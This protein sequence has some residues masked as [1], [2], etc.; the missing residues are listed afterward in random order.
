MAGSWWKQRS[1]KKKGREGSEIEGIS[2]GFVV[3]TISLSRLE[4]TKG[5]AALFAKRQGNWDNGVDVIGFGAMN[6][7]RLYRVQRVLLDGEAPIEEQ[8]LSPGGSAANTIYGL[9]KLGVKTGFMGAIGDDDEGQ[10]LVTDFQSVGTDASQIKIK[11]KAATGLVLCLT[12]KRGMRTLY[13]SPGANSLLTWQDI[14]LEYLN[15][16]RIIHL[17]S[18]VDDAQFDLQHQVLS[19]ISPT[20]MVSLAPGALYAK[21]GW[22][23]LAPFIRRAHILFLNQNELKELTGE[24]MEKGARRCSGEGCPIVVVTLGQGVDKKRPIACYIND[25]GQEYAIELPRSEKQPVVD[26]TGAGDAFA[27]GFLYGL[28]REKNLQECGYLGDIVA[29]LSIA[30]LGARPGLP[31]LP[32]LSQEYKEL[33]GQPL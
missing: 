16:A 17:S 18:F 20:V 22:H 4:F 28:V 2:I 8:A 9:A 1:K 27:T 6:I 30:K 3:A 5:F 25:G 10:M 21:R 12:D 23:A 19:A 13:V 7:D 31:S 33:W 15:R 29:R 26:T 14:D 24:E 11:S 32:E